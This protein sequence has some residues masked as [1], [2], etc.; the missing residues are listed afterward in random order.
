[1]HDGSTLPAYPSRVEIRMETTRCAMW[2]RMRILPQMKHPVPSVT[3][4]KKYVVTG[5]EL[6]SEVSHG[7][8]R[9][10]SNFQ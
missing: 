8:W 6:L 1:M 10:T 9:P 2:S 7:E 4:G 3:S 5:D